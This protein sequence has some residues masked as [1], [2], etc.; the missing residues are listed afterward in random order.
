MTHE[1]E[2]SSA[3]SPPKVEANW[4]SSTTTEF[5]EKLTTEIEG[6]VVEK[7]GYRRDRKVAAFGPA[8]ITVFFRRLR[9]VD[10]VC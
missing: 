2:Y 9:R 10:R 1:T 3:S 4:A 7:N 6:I 5:E 8:E